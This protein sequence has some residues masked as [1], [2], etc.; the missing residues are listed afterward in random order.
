MNKRTAKKLR[1]LR[2]KKETAVQTAALCVRPQ[3]NR[4]LLLTSRDTGRWVLPKGWT[5]S[6]K[7]DP[8]AALQ[9]A[10]EEAGV[11]GKLAKPHIGDFSYLKKLD[12]G[13]SIPVTCSVHAV[14]VS[15]MKKRFPEAGQR[16]QKWF[17]PKKAAKAVQEDGLKEILRSIA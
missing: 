17:T 1:R 7:T 13:F 6:G 8:E 4:V 3:D 10:W 5:M 12:I 14:Q 11:V 15:E 16:K 2:K 9:E